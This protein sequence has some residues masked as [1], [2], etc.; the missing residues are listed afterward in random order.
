MNIN[1]LGVFVIEVILISSSVA[2]GLFAGLMMTLVI[3]MQRMWGRMPVRDYIVAMQSFL[4]AAKGHPVITV[5]TLLPFLAPII[6]LIQLADDPA[7][8]RFGIILVG[9]VLAVGPLVVTLRFNFPIYDT[10]M[11]WQPDTVP[12]DW[13]QVRQRFFWLNVA[14]L[15]LALIAMV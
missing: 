14:R 6:A 10:I 8:V 9:T 11:S 12:D 7:T 15:T 2:L 1:V 5:L 3:V 13:Q 4:P